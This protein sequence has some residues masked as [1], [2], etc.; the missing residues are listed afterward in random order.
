M[1]CE[2][3]RS[4]GIDHYLDDFIIVGP[5]Q[6]R[7]C[8]SSL[9]VLEET[10]QQLGV[11]IA[12]EKC[13]GPSACLEFLGIEMD[14]LAMEL[15]LPQDKLNRL[16]TLLQGWWPRKACQIKDLQC[17]VGH[18]CHAC[19]VVRLG[20][21]FLR[22]MFLLLSGN[23]K[24]HH[25]I[26]LNRQFKADLEWW[27]VFL[28]QWNGTSMLFKVNMREPQV[29]V[30]SDASGSWGC[31][32]YWEGEWFQVTWSNHLEL[33]QAPIAAKEMAL[34]LVAAAVWGRR[35]RGLTVCCHCDNEAVVA[36]IQGNYCRQFKMA[37]MLCCLFFLEAKFGF[38]CSAIHIPGVN[39]GIAD[40]IKKPLIEVFCTLAPQARAEPTLV[41]RGLLEGLMGD[42]PWTS[43]AWERWFATI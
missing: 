38:I 19:R 36:S 39:N 16:R 27:N 10:C 13:Q 41:P 28:S 23:R 29:H 35:W 26:R 18:L 40:T 8:A 25:Y 34:I 37:H 30:F 43:A 15:C 24:G 21:R 1:D 12:A 31:G 22:G 9:R 4:R 33:E 3:Q 5:P 6:S 11:P 42:E 7:G 2:A 14:M 17:L 32:A 20:R